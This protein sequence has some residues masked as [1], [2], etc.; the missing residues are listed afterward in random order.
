MN[1]KVKGMLLT[2]LIAFATIAV[3]NRNATTRRLI[4]G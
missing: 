1:S 4:N 2:A 3:A